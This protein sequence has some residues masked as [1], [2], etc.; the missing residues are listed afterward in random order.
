MIPTSGEPSAATLKK[1]NAL[2]K[3]E[4]ETTKKR[5]EAS[6]RVLQLRKEQDSHLRD[7]IFQATREA[8]SDIAM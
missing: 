1:D 6:E 4:L 8:S 7:S 5:L 3:L 2:L